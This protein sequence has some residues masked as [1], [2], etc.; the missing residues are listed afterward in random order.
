MGRGH[1][2][3][4]PSLGS[5]ATVRSRDGTGGSKPTSTVVAVARV[6]RPTTTAA[7]VT[8]RRWWALL[9][10]LEVADV[11]AATGRLGTIG[12]RV[13]RRDDDVG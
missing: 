11:G 6:A 1:C 7:P 8:A 13:H 2:P 10:R 12:L 5:A 3:R 9:V 4:Q